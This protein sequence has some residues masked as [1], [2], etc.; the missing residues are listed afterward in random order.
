MPEFAQ[1]GPGRAGSG[2]VRPEHDGAYR[3]G[4]D[5]DG[6]ETAILPATEGP[7]L[8]RPYVAAPVPAPPSP[9]APGGQPVPPPPASDP[10]ATTLLPPAVEPSPGPEAEPA[11]HPPREL[12]LFPISEGFHEEDGEE[13]A[14]GS[15]RAARN[16]RRRRTGLVAV[17]GAGAIAIGV[18]LAFALTPGT[19][20]DRQAIPVL[21]T[22]AASPTDVP[23]PTDAANATPARTGSSPQ[24]PSTS[25]KPRPSAPRTKSAAPAPSSPP[26]QSPAPPA[27]P[28]PVPAP[29][30]S[31]APPPTSAAPTSAAPSPSAS[32][33]SPTPTAAPSP[34][35]RG[36]A[37][38]ALQSQLKSLGCGKAHSGV[39]DFPT[40]SEVGLFQ[41]N[42][43]L[44]QDQWGTVGPQTQAALDSGATC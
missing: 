37:V 21:P 36:P 38:V 41:S 8:V 42:N 19:P 20:P 43:Q 14:P 6:T 34:G 7:P 13:P 35:D 1:P 2:P 24:A 17:A 23:A 11:A 25:A 27:Q 32:T 33:A 12:G 28:A 30:T 4:P 31:Q 10:F 40:Q 15:R 16:A 44:W 18:G 5:P 22:T 26:A 3:H 39:Y 9:F 29:A